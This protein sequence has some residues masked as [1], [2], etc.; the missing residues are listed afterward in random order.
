MTSSASIRTAD[1]GD[2]FLFLSSPRRRGPI[3]R[4]FSRVRWL[5]VP[6]FPGTTDRAPFSVHSRG[7]PPSRGQARESR[8]KRKSWIPACAGTNGNRS[9]SLP[10]HAARLDR[11]GPF[12]DLGRNVFGEIFSAP[13]RRRRDRDAEAGIALAHHRRVDRFARR[14]VEL[15]HDRVRGVERQHQRSPG[16]AVEIAEAG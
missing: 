3:L 6:A 14:L 4:S 16:T 15:A 10:A 11:A 12:L 7:S 2:M 5:W 9:Y 8:L 13:P 1:C